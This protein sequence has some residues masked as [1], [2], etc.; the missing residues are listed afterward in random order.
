MVQEKPGSAAKP[1]AA[2]N[3]H[4]TGKAVDQVAFSVRLSLPLCMSNQSERLPSSPVFPRA[5]STVAV[6]TD[7]NKEF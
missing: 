7:R 3:E 2:R 4:A 1:R 5:H 6:A